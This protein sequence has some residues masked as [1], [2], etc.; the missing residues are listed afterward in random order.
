M[1]NVFLPPQELVLQPQ[2][3]SE[4]Q[5]QQ[6]QHE[7]VKNNDD[8]YSS[9]CTICSIVPDELWAYIFSFLPLSQKLQTM[10]L[11]KY[12]AN[13]GPQSIIDRAISYQPI[14]F[15][16]MQTALQHAEQCTIRFPSASLSLSIE[17]SQESESEVSN[18]DTF[19]R[20][21]F[22]LMQSVSFIDLHTLSC[23]TSEHLTYLHQ[24]K[25][26]HLEKCSKIDDFSA[27]ARIPSLSLG[28]GC[29]FQCLPTLEKPQTK[30]N[31]QDD[32]NCHSNNNNNNNNNIGTTITNES[33]SSS[34][35]LLSSLQQPKRKENSAR[36]MEHL[37]LRLGGSQVPFIDFAKFSKHLTSISIMSVFGFPVI[38]I[39]PQRFAKL[40]TLDVRS[41]GLFD[42]TTNH[43][44][45]NVEDLRHRALLFQKPA[46]RY[47]FEQ[48]SNLQELCLFNVTNIP[49]I[50]ALAKLVA[51]DISYSCVEHISAQMPCLKCLDA[52]RSKLVALEQWPMLETLDISRTQ[53]TKLPPYFFLKT[54]KATHLCFLLDLWEWQNHPS[55][56][57]VDLSWSTLPCSK[58][59]AWPEL[60]CLNISHTDFKDP[61]TQTLLDSV[62]LPT[63]L[64]LAVLDMSDTKQIGHVSYCPLLTTWKA[65]NSNL[66]TLW[67]YDYHDIE[68][69]RLFPET[70]NRVLCHLELCSVKNVRHVPHHYVCLEHL[71]L[72]NNPGIQSLPALS[73]LKV[74]LMTYTGIKEIPFYPLLE[75]LEAS[76]STIE[77]ISPN[78]EDC[79]CLRSLN[80]SHTQHLKK[81]PHTPNLLLCDIS[82]SC[83]EEISENLPRLT[84]LH[85]KGSLLTT[86]APSYPKLKILDISFT[87]I[88]KLPLDCPQLQYLKMIGF[89]Y[90]QIPTYKIPAWSSPHFS[91]KNHYP[92]STHNGQHFVLEV[93]NSVD[94]EEYDDDFKKEQQ[95]KKRRISGQT[96]EQ[97]QEMLLSSSSSEGGY[98][99]PDIISIAVD[100]Q[101]KP[102]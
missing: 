96:I 6:Q 77:K 97:E 54:L 17:M 52:N 28:Y 93:T 30:T 51:L 36:K 20:T 24:C 11:C 14:V 92:S 26:V 4:K 32:S 46:P 62:T 59:Y 40:K 102:R 34:S 3:S 9:T 69:K 61:A 65:N 1:L 64:K 82:N 74:L 8:E 100:V 49:F 29:N 80:V 72:H 86:L 25:F 15:K 22:P 81:L 60:V 66:E 87:H 88:R 39:P 31:Q 48:F 58:L 47:P 90:H 53:V 85:A 73:Q 33:T 78:M 55:L 70:Q 41:C 44:N 12:F 71:S 57:R 27:L 94:H 63:Y 98:Y 91:I 43:E 67:M 101:P 37:K 45:L 99:W 83:V 19:A 35:S 21:I 38:N 84:T 76:H 75:T 95:E 2:E 56:T 23:L 10:L 16:T 7:H 68:N 18:I 42:G 50:P 5:Q 89:V 79:L 13:T